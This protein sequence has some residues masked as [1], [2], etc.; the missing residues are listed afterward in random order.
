MLT[1]SV[2]INREG[3]ILVESMR[4]RLQG[5]YYLT[6]KELRNQCKLR[7]LEDP[8]ADT[9]RSGVFYFHPVVAKFGIATDF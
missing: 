4:N 6:R 8:G 2:M 9:K 7:L 3:E 5:L 1:M